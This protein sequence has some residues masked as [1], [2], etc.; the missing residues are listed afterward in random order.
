MNSNFCNSSQYSFVTS[1]ATIQYLCWVHK[2]VL[3]SDHRL[4]IKVNPIKTR[5]IFS[6]QNCINFIQLNGFDTS[7]LNIITLLYG[8]CFYTV[9]KVNTSFPCRY[10]NIVIILII[11]D[12]FRIFST[13]SHGSREKCYA[14][15]KKTFLD[16]L[17]K[18]SLRYWIF[19]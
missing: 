16:Y 11:T 12:Y 3:F 17:L 14:L 10:N 9:A 13:S 6:S 7:H 8:N 18:F 2:Q 1:S 5:D 15:L 4:I 19:E